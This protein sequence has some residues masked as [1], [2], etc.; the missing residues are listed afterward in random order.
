MNP[1]FEKAL[2]I[3]AYVGQILKLLLSWILYPFTPILYFLY[4]LLL[5]FI[6]FCQA[7]WA[8]VLYPAQCFPG[9]LVE[10]I[11]IYLST[12]ALIGLFAGSILLFVHQGFISVLKLNHSPPP[13]E[14]AKR[15]MADH[16]A[17]RKERKE[18][19]K[20]TPLTHV[21]DLGYVSPKSAGISSGHM[22][23]LA[24]PAIPDSQLKWAR[25]SLITSPSIILEEGSSDDYF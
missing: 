3:V 1:F 14:P 6:H 5:P 15:T 17:R 7:I 21:D 8:I 23:P 13:P 4:L 10:T 22:S 2:T 16:R 19:I 20:R 12:A 9:S 11:Y 24:S 25:R 18:K